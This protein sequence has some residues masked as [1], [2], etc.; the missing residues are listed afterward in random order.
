MMVHKREDRKAISTILWE[1]FRAIRTIEL[2]EKGAVQHYKPK[3]QRMEEWLK[4]G[5]DAKQCWVKKLMEILWML[6]TEIG[7]RGCPLHKFCSPTF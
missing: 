5:L 3:S 2:K 1:P 4:S 6:T 7:R